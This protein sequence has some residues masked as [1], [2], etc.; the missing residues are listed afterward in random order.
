[1]IWVSHMLI[2]SEGIQ[3]SYGVQKMQLDTFTRDIIEGYLFLDL[4]NMSLVQQAEGEEAGALGYP[5]LSTVVSGMELLGG[6]LQTD[7][8]YSDSAINSARYFTHYWEKYLVKQSQSYAPYGD[9]FWKLVRHGV[10][11]T[12]IA[13]AGITVTKGAPGYHLRHHG[14]GLFNIDCVQFYKDFHNSYLGPVRQQLNN[15]E[16][17]KIVEANITQLFK[18]SEEVSRSKLAAISVASS[19]GITTTTSGTGGPQGATAPRS[20]TN[21]TTMLERLRITSTPLSGATGVT[22]QSAEAFK[23]A[24]EIRTDVDRSKQED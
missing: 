23:K 16:F 3:S 11:H 8:L 22:Q 19:G 15:P 20:S 17:Q 18:E 1:M 2:V 9:I 4:K 6:V 5:M 12:Y 24:I 13:K 14:D 7:A 21:T 10:A